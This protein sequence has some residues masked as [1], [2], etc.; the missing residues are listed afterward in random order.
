MKLAIVGSRNF[1]NYAKFCQ[2]MEEFFE[3]RREAVGLEYEIIS[4]GAPGTDSLAEQWAKEHN[5]KC[6]VFKPNWNKHGKKAGILRNVDIIT[7]CTEVVA[8]PDYEI[9]RGTQHAMSVA[10]KQG[11]RVKEYDFKGEV[12][13]TPKLK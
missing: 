2:F 9:G 7:A 1:L 11:K 6:T 5:I 4:G 3:S 13:L 12:R 8:F 10:R